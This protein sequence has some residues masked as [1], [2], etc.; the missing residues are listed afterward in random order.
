MERDGSKRLLIQ[1]IRIFTNLRAAEVRRHKSLNGL[2]N[3][4][5]EF[6]CVLVGPVVVSAILLFT[7]F[8]P[9]TGFFSVI[10]CRRC[11]CVVIGRL[12]AYIMFVPVVLI[13]SVN[14]F[15]P[16]G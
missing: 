1:T 9:Y 10:G 13:S 11:V 4:P 6:Y 12:H 2:R 14:A 7:L 5:C 8:L 3:A 15:S 16:L